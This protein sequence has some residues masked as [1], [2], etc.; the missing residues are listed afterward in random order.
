MKKITLL[1]LAATAAML[2]TAK[3]AMAMGPKCTFPDTHIPAPNWVCGEANV[4]GLLV[5]TVSV[6]QPF[7]AAQDRTAA[8]RATQARLIE[9]LEVLANQAMAKY[10]PNQTLSEEQMQ[11]VISQMLVQTK[12]FGKI[13][14][15]YGRLFVLVGQDVPTFQQNLTRVIKLSTQADPAMWQKYS[16]NNTPEQMAMVAVMDLLANQH[17]KSMAYLTQAK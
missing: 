15:P 4:P 16:S 7:K 8:L 9:K 6:E 12:A 14:D 1:T 2:L 13:M 5:S 3:T 10:F 11:L 17:E